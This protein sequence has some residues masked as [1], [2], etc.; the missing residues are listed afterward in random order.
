M[1]SG[2][3]FAGLQSARLQLNLFSPRF[4]LKFP[5]KFFG[6]SHAQFDQISDD[7]P[8]CFRLVFLLLIALFN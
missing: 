8:N 2:R 5:V 6:D 1:Q 7:F 4:S 3:Y